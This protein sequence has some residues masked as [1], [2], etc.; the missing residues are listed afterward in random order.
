M[1]LRSRAGGQG[2]ATVREE[3]MPRR[4]GARLARVFFQLAAP[5]LAGLSTANL[6]KAQPPEP[7]AQRPPPAQ[8]PPPA[9]PTPPATPPA[10]PTEQHGPSQVFPD[11]GFPETR[12]APEG[13]IPTTPAPPGP[14][15]VYPPP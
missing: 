15:A 9:P 2:L 11:G 6:A 12:S 3:T 13:G 7:P 4:T 1:R 10:I 8:L 5:A 14:V